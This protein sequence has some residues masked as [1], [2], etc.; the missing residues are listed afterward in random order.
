MD[1]DIEEITNWLL[2]ESAWE[3][4]KD[5]KLA[6]IHASYLAL[7]LFIAKFEYDQEPFT[8]EEI[9][10][11]TNS[12]FETVVKDPVLDFDTIYEKLIAINLTIYDLRQDTARYF[13]NNATAEIAIKSLK[14]ALHTIR[15]KINWKQEPSVIISTLSNLKKEIK[16]KLH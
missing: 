9:T 14:N 10:N 8:I 6:S 3:S 13:D 4:E 15:E 11:I 16:S 5:K 1:T 12:I 7:Q 2:Y